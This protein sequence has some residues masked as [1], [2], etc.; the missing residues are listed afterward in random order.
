LIIR[1]E[2]KD[3]LINDH[4]DAERERLVPAVELAN[5]ATDIKYIDSLEEEL[6]QKQEE[7]Q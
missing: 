1:S 7:E 4:H 6:K 3:T 2:R 5:L